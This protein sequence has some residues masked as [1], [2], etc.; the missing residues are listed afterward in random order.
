M[1]GQYSDPKLKI[2]A[3][4]SNKP[5]AEKIAEA[6]GVP[7]GKISVDRFSDGEIRIKSGIIFEEVSKLCN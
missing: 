7:L 3:L 2:F 1:S 6:V 4:N 5:L